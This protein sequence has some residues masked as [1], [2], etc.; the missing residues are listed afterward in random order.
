MSSSPSS[1]T[2]RGGQSGEGNSSDLIAGSQYWRKR[3]PMGVPGPMRQRY[4]VSSGLSICV[5]PSASGRVVYSIIG[6]SNPACQTWAHR[7]DSLH[8]LVGREELDRAAL[9]VRSD[10]WCGLTEQL[11]A[12][13]PSRQDCLHEVGQVLTVLDERRGVGEPLEDHGLRLVLIEVGV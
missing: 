2:R 9:Q 11:A 4:S 1:L 5:S 10:L 12:A 7:R 13:G 8:H 3:L 6:A